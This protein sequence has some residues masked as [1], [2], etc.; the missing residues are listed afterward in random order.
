MYCLS[1]LSKIQNAS[2]GRAELGKE[3]KKNEVSKARVRA[4]HCGL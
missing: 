3:R 1:D 4:E 2:V